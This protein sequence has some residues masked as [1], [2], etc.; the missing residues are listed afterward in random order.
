MSKEEKKKKPTKEQPKI[1][2]IDLEDDDDAGL[3]AQVQAMQRNDPVA[4]M[5]ELKRSAPSSSSGK[6]TKQVSSSSSSSQSQKR[7]REETKDAT[8][9]AAV[10]AAASQEQ[11]AKRQKIAHERAVENTVFHLDSFD[12]D[13]PVDGFC[14]RLQQLVYCARREDYDDRDLVGSRLF[15]WMLFTCV[16]LAPHDNGDLWFLF[17]NHYLV[18]FLQPRMITPKKWA[19][20]S[21]D[22]PLDFFV[23]FSMVIVSV[24]TDKHSPYS[25]AFSSDALTLA[26]V[27][28]STLMKEVDVNMDG[29]TV[30]IPTDKTIGKRI[31]KEI[32]KRLHAHTQNAVAGDA[33]IASYGWFIWDWLEEAV[34]W[35]KAKTL[36]DEK[37]TERSMEYSTPSPEDDW[38]K[39]QQDAG[40]I[41]RRL[42]PILKHHESSQHKCVLLRA[43]HD[44]EKKLHTVMTPP[45]AGK[46]KNHDEHPSSASRIRG[47]T[48]A[49]YLL[50]LAEKDLFDPS[51]NARAVEKG[52]H[53]TLDQGQVLKRMH[54]VPFGTDL[55]AR[56]SAYIRIRKLVA[57]KTR[58]VKGK[59]EPTS[60]STTKAPDRLV[61]QKTKLETWAIDFKKAN[62]NKQVREWISWFV[63]RDLANGFLNNIGY[64]GVN[65][66]T[67]GIMEN[68]F[69]RY[70]NLTTSFGI[71]AGV[72]PENKDELKRTLT[73]FQRVFRREPRKVLPEGAEFYM[74]AEVARFR[75][76]GAD[77]NLLLVYAGRVWSIASD[78]PADVSE[79][80]IEDTSGLSL[81]S[82]KN[83][84]NLTKERVIREAQ[85][86]Q[87]R[88][89]TWW[90]SG[91][92]YLCTFGVSKT[93]TNVKKKETRHTLVLLVP[94]DT[95][96]LLK[97]HWTQVMGQRITPDEIDKPL[98][99]SDLRSMYG[100][101]RRHD[102]RRREWSPESRMDHRVFDTLSSFSD[103]IGDLETKNRALKDLTD[104]PS[105]AIFQNL[106]TGLSPWVSW[107]TK[108]QKMIE[109]KG[110][111]LITEEV[112]NF[113]DAILSAIRPLNVLVEQGQGNSIELMQTLK[114]TLP[115]LTESN[116]VI[117]AGMVDLLSAA[118]AR[119]YEDVARQRFKHAMSAS[120]AS[121]AN[122]HMRNPGTKIESAADA[123]LLATSWKAAADYLQ[124]IVD[125]KEKDNSSVVLRLQSYITTA[126][127]ARELAE[128]A[129]GRIVKRMEE[130]E[131]DARMESEVALEEEGEW[132]KKL[133]QKQQLAWDINEELKQIIDN[134]DD[135]I[136]NL[137]D[138]RI[139]ADLVDRMSQG[140]QKKQQQ[141]Q[142]IGSEFL[143]M[144]KNAS[145]FVQQR[146][147]DP[148]VIRAVGDAQALI[149]KT[150]AIAAEFKDNDKTDLAI[151]LLLVEQLR[152]ILLTTVQTS[153]SEIRKISRLEKMNKEIGKGKKKRTEAKSSSSVL[154]YLDD[155]IS[156]GGGGDD[157]EFIDPEAIQQTLATE[158]DVV[159]SLDDAA[160]LTNVVEYCRLCWIGT[161][162]KTMLD[163]SLQEQTVEELQREAEFQKL[164][165]S[166]MELVDTDVIQPMQVG[167]GDD[168]LKLDLRD[169]LNAQG[170]KMLRKRRAQQ[171][172]RIKKLDESKLMAQQA[173]EKKE[174][175]KKKKKANA[176]EDGSSSSDDE[177]DDTIILKSDA[178]RASLRRKLTRL[179]IAFRLNAIRQPDSGLA[180]KTE[181][182]A[183]FTRDLV[184]LPPNAFYQLL[185]RE[186]DKAFK[187]RADG[188]LLLEW[189]ALRTASDKARE[190]WNERLIGANRRGDED[191]KDT[192]R[193]S[194]QASDIESGLKLA[195]EHLVA[196]TAALGSRA[197]DVYRNNKRHMNIPLE[198]V[199]ADICQLLHGTRRPRLWT[200]VDTAKLLVR[201]ATSEITD[202]W[203]MNNAASF[204]P[205]TSELAR[206]AHRIS[207][208]TCIPYRV[209]R[210]QLILGLL[211]NLPGD[212]QYVDQRDL[213]ITQQQEEK[214]EE[215]SD[216]KET[217]KIKKKKKKSV[218]KGGG[219]GEEDNQVF[220]FADSNGNEFQFLREWQRNVIL[221]KLEYQLVE[222]DAINKLATASSSRGTIDIDEMIA[223]VLAA[224][225][226]AAGR[227][228]GVKGKK[229]NDSEQRKSLLTTVPLEA[230]S[231]SQSAVTRM[232]N[233]IYDQATGSQPLVAM[234][235]SEPVDEHLPEM[236][237][238]DVAAT[239][240]D[241]IKR[242]QIPL[243][244]SKNISD[245]KSSAAAALEDDDGGADDDT[246]A[247]PNDDVIRS[248]RDVVLRAI[249]SKKMEWMQPP[250]SSSLQLPLDN[251]V[252][253]QPSISE[254]RM[255]N[256]LARDQLTSMH[257]GIHTQV[258]RSMGQDI[259]ERP[260]DPKVIQSEL[261]CLL[262]LAIEQSDGARLLDPL[263][264]RLDAYALDWETKLAEFKT[265]YW[266]LPEGTNL[267]GDDLTSMNADAVQTAIDKFGMKGDDANKLILGLIQARNN[268]YQLAHAGIRYFQYLLPLVQC[269]RDT[270]QVTEDEEKLYKWTI[271]NPALE[272]RFVDD[273]ADRGRNERLQ[274]NFFTALQRQSEIMSVHHSVFLPTH[275][276]LQAILSTYL[277]LDLPD[278]PLKR[279]KEL[280]TLFPCPEEETKQA[281]LVVL[282]NVRKMLGWQN[283]RDALEYHVYR[284]CINTDNKQQSVA[285]QIARHRDPLVPVHW[286][287]GTVQLEEVKGYSYWTDQAMI[288]RRRA[289]ALLRLHD[290]VAMEDKRIA[291]DQNKQQ[292]VMDTLA[293][294]LAIFR[295]PRWSV[296][297][298]SRIL[299]RLEIPVHLDNSPFAIEI[300]K[301]SV[302]W[303]STRHAYRSIFSL[304]DG[305][306]IVAPGRK[307][308]AGQFASHLAEEWALRG[309]G[310]QDMGLKLESDL[311]F[312]DKSAVVD[313][314]HLKHTLESAARFIYFATPPTAGGGGVNI[315]QEGNLAHWATL[316]SLEAKT[317]D[318]KIV[319]T[320]LKYRQSIIASL[321]GGKST[322]N[323]AR[324]AEL[325]QKA[326]QEV[327]K[328][329]ST[330]TT[331]MDTSGDSKQQQQ[332]KKKLQTLMSLKEAQIELMTRPTI[333]PRSES[334][335]NRAAQ[336][337]ETPNS[338]LQR[339]VLKDL[340]ESDKMDT[341]GKMTILADTEPVV[342]TRY[343]GGNEA[344]VSAVSRT[345]PPPPSSSAASH[346]HP[347]LLGAPTTV[348]VPL[349]ARRRLAFPASSSLTGGG[350]RIS[351][352]VP[353]LVSVS[354]GAGV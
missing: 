236:V 220:I 318:R 195:E 106:D 13:K 193:S 100:Q 92:K 88:L 319:G 104:M 108:A 211:P 238:M 38:I 35:V 227:R 235:H 230:F 254:P 9:A 245:T 345:P 221:A 59:F 66:P 268:W 204:M 144:L 344:S 135:A 82:V 353:S 200:M 154:Q 258:L 302:I 121:L 316:A 329:P 72:V 126:R 250:S 330:T 178:D 140:I 323:K 280:M 287:N 253:E 155:E 260:L 231:D 246:T 7:P 172:A 197:Y 15:R 336:T 311:Y 271:P 194:I 79:H 165:L 21:F 96:L 309:A 3:L 322:A 87:F 332:P 110:N 306:E 115:P 99:T 191:R 351:A 350:L 58:Y 48:A 206:T 274:L 32:L 219:G 342:K 301:V 130:D 196:M 255:L 148:S 159:T 290:N 157:D 10:A 340:D 39:M 167:A 192:T 185:L 257:T 56:V 43:L 180:I 244:E 134:A 123:E 312:E 149:A 70:L 47:V 51:F 216:G 65:D 247:T 217:K 209:L 223:A 310:G 215:G 348:G 26:R 153:I 313:P 240:A 117:Y 156:G 16:E 282:S 214:E 2:T 270:L 45:A 40:M 249:F 98:T 291:G 163:T 41:F 119:Y 202:R 29:K 57:R 12:L 69:K 224:D 76:S 338:E 107:Q 95:D 4:Q 320:L 169:R 103:I 118:R 276:D 226:K 20:N 341:R 275:L 136:Q 256:K 321:D 160:L 294:A 170:V 1:V 133:I 241:E 184:G 91:D 64:S 101:L 265:Q 150:P 259:K 14:A 75:D 33:P 28:H 138:D 346:V 347:A 93:V 168:D 60:E 5:Q 158:L 283:P 198:T 46:I 139:L 122:Q 262:K 190:D 17:C 174:K 298:L 205:Q 62:D 264:A 129:R 300:R 267:K 303:N 84:S 83:K 295:E 183:P 8:G 128:R 229:D 177:D 141:Q 24:V 116:A 102:R 277:S 6:D 325:K 213:I 199:M 324:K 94:T 36:N 142:Q 242:N 181:E 315:S 176:M 111:N 293:A 187:Q 339:L 19:K 237:A 34:D 68:L 182:L 25:P 307:D 109:S 225:P 143:R 44:V 266:K 18:Q 239:F 327:S 61:T 89:L 55:S 243:P 179:R 173:D 335:S 252:E 85:G 296:D 42:E 233:L 334:S 132:I 127:N 31:S 207:L 349:R 73:A 78:S 67:I 286:E 125:N 27:I 49:V 105:V 343:F 269:V 326:K 23:A 234:D 317:S 77:G 162:F 304:A 222:E 337:R 145:E 289:A 263:L 251:E 203:Q 90:V 50:I 261:V 331:N 161:E 352:A 166:Q 208:A 52:L 272:V 147:K 354:A 201:W 284:H 146:P 186:E 30:D 81:I 328:L 281:D 189:N 74:W 278:A 63:D 97:L 114:R 71:A 188:L 113:N 151:R 80:F 292:Q 37:K 218:M 279:P 175:P 131:E 314:K 120:N 164:E 86:N 152:A 305:K 333:D 53:A 232:C 124:D 22:G 288:D 285:D 308:E 210:A 228:K 273:I 297:S 299:R 112:R 171:K 11:K 137:R 212:G 54:D 248:K